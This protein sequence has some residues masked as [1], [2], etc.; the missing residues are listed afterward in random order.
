MP[1]DLGKELPTSNPEELPKACHTCSLAISPICKNPAP[2]LSIHYIEQKVQWKKLTDV[3]VTGD[4]N[5]R[6][7]E[8]KKN[9]A[10]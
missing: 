2:S 10:A 6:G 1:R 9:T 4:P 5:R 7:V 8:G 3:H